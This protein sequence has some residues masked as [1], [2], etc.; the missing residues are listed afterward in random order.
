MA[1]PTAGCR[2]K[3]PVPARSLTATQARS[4]PDAKPLVDPTFL[5]L[6][7]TETTPPGARIVR[8]SD[9]YSWGLTPEIVELHQST[10]PV[11]IRFELEGY[12]PVTREVP[13]LTD[14]EVKVVLEPIPKAALPAASRQSKASKAHGKSR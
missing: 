7:W 6:V 5:V 1:W 3:N 13:A 12:L 8:V 2:G 11:A 14:G 10:Q 4:A 9:G